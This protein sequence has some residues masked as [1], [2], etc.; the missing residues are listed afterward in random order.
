V[1]IRAS[2]T[3]RV[4]H[5]VDCKND[6]AAGTT[7]NLA[8]EHVSVMR[9]G[10][11]DVPG[12]IHSTIADLVVSYVP[13]LDTAFVLEVAGLRSAWKTILELFPPRFAS[14]AGP[15]PYQTLVCWPPIAWLRDAGLIARTVDV[16]WAQLRL[17]LTMKRPTPAPMEASARPR[18]NA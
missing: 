13:A 17:P 11:R 10:R 5:R 1:Q 8:L 18:R 7:G 2:A 12:W 6:V 14:T 9:R 3:G 15:E 16:V 4:I